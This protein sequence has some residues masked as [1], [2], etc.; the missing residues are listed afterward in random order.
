MQDQSASTISGAG[1]GL[2]SLCP[3]APIRCAAVLGSGG[4]DRANE[5]HRPY[6]AWTDE[7]IESE[8]RELVGELGRWPG[9]QELRRAGR[10]GLA[11][12]IGRYGGAAYWAARVGVPAPRGYGKRHW[13]DERI[14]QALE[15][16]LAGRSTWPSETEFERA[17][18]GALRSA[19]RRYGGFAAWAAKL[20]F[21]PP[22]TGRPPRA[23]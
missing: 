3:G 1:S 19:V 11:K 13:T 9:T 16:F 10:S 7:R 18:L 23:Q 12:A 5:R 20:G 6:Q 21:P 17:G 2:S 14:E 15:P 22:R 4:E 8:L